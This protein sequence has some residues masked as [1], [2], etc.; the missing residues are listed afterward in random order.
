M[1]CP[2]CGAPSEEG[3]SYCASCGAE[4]PG[5]EKR[6]RERRSLRQRLQDLVGTT[7]RARA[8]TALTVLAALVAVVAFV[9]LDADD[10]G[11]IPR[12]AYTVASDRLCL[13]SKRS[14][15]V[16]QRQS[17]RDRGSDPGSFAQNLVPIVHRWRRE[18]VAL[19]LPSDRIEQVDALI[20]ALREVEIELAALARVA[21]E[22]D[23]AATVAKAAQVDKTTGRVEAAAA[24]L[25]LERCAALRL[26]ASPAEVG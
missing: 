19:G 25:G 12:D 14:I 6:P 7:P 20:A 8:L 1:H 2:R 24:D 11:E 22:G 4:L 9:A 15:A 3:A 5:A 16:S 21:D 23:K 10:E 17:V 18:Q 13:E 26:G